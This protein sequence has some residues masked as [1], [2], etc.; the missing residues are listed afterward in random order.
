MRNYN[1]N[2]DEIVYNNALHVIIKDIIIIGEQIYPVVWE[3]VKALEM[4]RLPVVSLVS[5]GAKPNRRFYQ[6]CQS[7]GKHGAI[8]YKSFNP[9]QKEADLYFICDVPHLLKTS[10]N[11]FSNSFAH[12]K[13]RTLKVRSLYIEVPSICVN[14][15][16]L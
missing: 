14:C 7:S 8:P 13:S 3:V 10:R 4:Y 9:Y 12:S 15:F 5:D 6:M 2:Y 1:Y 16:N 11:C